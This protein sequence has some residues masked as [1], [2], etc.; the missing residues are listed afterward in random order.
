MKA[1]VPHIRR[2]ID[3]AGLGYPTIDCAVP[4]L[5]AD[6]EGR[7]SIDWMM[8]GYQVKA[9]DIVVFELLSN[10]IMSDVE[11]WP[12]KTKQ[13]RKT[14]YHW[15]KPCILEVEGLEKELEQCYKIFGNF[16]QL[17]QIVLFP[18]FPRYLTGPCC[19][20]PAHFENWEKFAEKFLG[21][22]HSVL[23]TYYKEVRKTFRNVR[24]LT[25]DDISGGGG[26]GGDDK[27]VQ[28]VAQ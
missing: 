24:A 4:G 6:R 26:N 16:P 28:R 10:S 23:K 17:T 15:K 21:R 13:G 7:K 9:E 8:E 14:I 3:E 12:K 20:D 5:R 22:S 11:G 25:Y 1:L 18:I 2:A 19:G 27:G